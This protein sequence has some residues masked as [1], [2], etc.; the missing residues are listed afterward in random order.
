MWT[1]RPVLDRAELEQILAL[2]RANLAQALTSEE[3]RTQ[4]F[5][6]VEHTLPSLEEMHALAPSLVV[7]AGDALAGYA[8]TM[9]LEAERC[10]P[11]LAP[12]FALLRSLELRGTRLSARRFYVMGQVCVAR[13][14]R[15]QGVFEALYAG[16]RRVYSTRFDVLVT[17]I[18]TRNTRSLRAHERAGFEPI[19]RYRDAVDEWLIVAWD[20][21]TPEQR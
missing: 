21:G 20:W 15:G 19:H 10:A 3:A 4:G 1:A 13:E 17:E 16:H 18:A 5:V 8:L 7:K 2:E 12:M 9:T 11:I 14:Y 6:T